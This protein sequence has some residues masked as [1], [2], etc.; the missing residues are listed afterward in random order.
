MRIERWDPADQLALRGCQAA[1]DAA[2][3]ID[4]PG[5]S[6]MPARVL[7]VFLRCG[8]TGDPADAWITRVPGPGSVNG[9]Y[10]LELPD[11]ENR[12]RAVLQIVVHPAHRRRGTGRALLRHAAGRAA[13]AGRTLLTG[14]VHDGSAGDAFATAT[15]MKPGITSTLR[16]LDLRTLPAERLAALH[17]AAAAAAT[18]YS[19]VRWSGPTPPEYLTPLARVLQAF[20]DAPHDAG[21]EAESWDADRVRQR[22]DAPLQA[23]GLRTYTVAAVHDA[24]GELAGMSAVS[25][26]P[27]DARWGHQGLT[28]VTRPH[29]GHRLGL[30]L[31]TAML[32]WLVVAEPQV[33]QIE[34]GNATANKHMIEVND[35]LGYVTASPH[36][37]TCEL[38]VATALA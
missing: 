36:L 12:D 4:Y 2:L 9:W 20:A 33:E 8:F 13:A 38:E 21:V 17:A 34:T 18:G 14:Q 6:R 37:H 24:S 15:G 7:S 28:A 1:W 30:L 26:S 25:V 35:A 31:K 10:R 23:M 5:G 3:E 16:R 22:G 11:L 29:R 19:L 27:D 32:E